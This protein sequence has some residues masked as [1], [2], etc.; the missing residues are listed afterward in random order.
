MV[1]N[2]KKIPQ[3]FIDRL[4]KYLSINLEG[5]TS[6]MNLILE[7]LSKSKID[8]FKVNLEIAFCDIYEKLSKEPKFKIQSN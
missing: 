3:G 8:N 1:S 5:Y 4:T 2:D 7:H 6:L